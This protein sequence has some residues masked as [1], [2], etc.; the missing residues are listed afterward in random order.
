M[1]TSIQTSNPVTGLTQVASGLHLMIV[2]IANM[3]R[4]ELQ[5]SAGA[6]VATVAKKT[7]RRAAPPKKHRIHRKPCIAPDCKNVSKG[8]RFHFCCEEH[9]DAPAKTIKEWKKAKSKE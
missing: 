9:R 4:Q 1:K 3:V 2:A 8:P 5:M 6:K 7:V